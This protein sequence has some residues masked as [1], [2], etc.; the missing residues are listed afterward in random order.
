[1]TSPLR[2]EGGGGGRKERMNVV[3]RGLKSRMEGEKKAGTVG[4]GGDM[5]VKVGNGTSVGSIRRGAHG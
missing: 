3:D 1:L 5:A 4:G 2:V